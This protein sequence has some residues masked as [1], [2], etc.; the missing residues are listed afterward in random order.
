M[1]WILGPMFRLMLKRAG[2]K[3]DSA[4]DTPEE[5]VAN[6]EL[7]LRK[8]HPNLVRVLVKMQEKGHNWLDKHGF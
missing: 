2:V 8:F 1:T 4:I 3:V 5:R 6:A 7:I